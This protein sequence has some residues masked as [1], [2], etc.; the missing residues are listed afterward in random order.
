LLHAASSL[1][2]RGMLALDDPLNDAVSAYVPTRS[3]FM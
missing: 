2:L 3:G 1:E